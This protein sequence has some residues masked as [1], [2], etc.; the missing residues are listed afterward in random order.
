MATIH[1][2]FVKYHGTGNDFIVVD[3]VNGV[4]A[5]FSGEQY[6]HWCMF[7]AG[8]ALMS[9]LCPWLRFLSTGGSK[10]CLF[11]CPLWQP[12]RLPIDTLA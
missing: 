7:F 4:G 8:Y 9:G 6:S 2:P 12:K 1:L 5:S 11:S 10:M 3:G